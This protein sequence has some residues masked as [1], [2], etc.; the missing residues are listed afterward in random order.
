MLDPIVV[1]GLDE[2]LLCDVVDEVALLD[3]VLLLAVVVVDAGV[4]DDVV[5]WD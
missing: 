3:V 4:E 1:V 5:L 2:V